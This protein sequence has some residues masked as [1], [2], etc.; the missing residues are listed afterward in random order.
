MFTGLEPRDP[1]EVSEL[2]SGEEPGDCL[3]AQAQQ[4]TGIGGLFMAV[5]PSY[6]L[7]LCVAG[8]RRGR[9]AAWF[10]VAAVY[11]AMS[12]VAG[13]QIASLAADQE[14]TDLF[15]AL[16]AMD[17]GEAVD[18]VVPL[19]MPMLLFVALLPARRWFTVRAPAG[20]YRKAAVR[21]ATVAAALAAGYVA[22][23]WAVAGQFTP[24]PDLGQD[25]GRR[26]GPLPAAGI[27]A[28]PDAGIHSRGGSRRTVV[29]GSGHGVL[30][31]GGGLMLQSFRRP[32]L[33]QDQAD[34]RHARAILEAAGGSNLAW[35]TTWP[36]NEYWFSP[37]G[38]SV[39]AYRVHASVAL[40]LGDP[41]GPEDE[42]RASRWTGSRSSAPTWGGPHASTRPPAPC[43]PTPPAGAGGTCRWRRRRWCPWRRC[44]SRERSSRMSALR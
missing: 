34:A 23:A 10:G 17:P 26:S 3:L 8:L 16:A 14:E 31:A 13:A 30:A 28:G 11:A 32:A 20:T 38:R 33:P 5:V 9:R 6:L 29:C 39:V 41:V 37:S 27:G 1:A 43:G 42:H 19:I 44:P 36:D 2:C 18:E 12:V 40:T 21:A 7:L 24:Q 25:P 15:Q 22:A 4:L 35:M